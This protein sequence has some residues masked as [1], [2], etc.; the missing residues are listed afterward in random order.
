MFANPMYDILGIELKEKEIVLKMDSF[1]HSA[2]F[3][4]I[5]ESACLKMTDFTASVSVDMDYAIDRLVFS[6]HLNSG[7]RGTY[8]AIRLFLACL[9]NALLDDMRF[10]EQDIE[11]LD[12]IKEYCNIFKID[13]KFISEKEYG[14]KDDI[15]EI[16]D[17]TISFVDRIN[18]IINKPLEN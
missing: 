15:L 4:K 7:K 3:L 14:Y 13:R 8:K 10:M 2:A 11:L 5:L 17:N 16:I 6:I 12:L 18:Q 1:I 9:N